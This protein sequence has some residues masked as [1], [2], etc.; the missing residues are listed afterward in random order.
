MDT[1]GQQRTLTLKVR[2]L[3]DLRASCCSASVP[4]A[5][6]IV[7]APAVI[8]SRSYHLA[9][10]CVVVYQDRDASKVGIFSS[11]STFGALHNAIRRVAR[12]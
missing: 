12:C 6:H 4:E 9:R 3:T 2:Q 5:A 8:Q 10:L 11:H 7:S 1:A